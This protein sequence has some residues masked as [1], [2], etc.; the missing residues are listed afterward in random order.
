[1]TKEI[2][3]MTIGVLSGRS[4][5]VG[6]PQRGDHYLIGDGGEP[7]VCE[8]SHG[9]FAPVRAIVFG[10]SCQLC[11]CGLL[12]DECETPAACEARAKEIEEEQGW[13]DELKASGE[14]G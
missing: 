2:E 6:R 7:I 8:G 10:P 13:R 12:T 5:V 11:L 1:M 9:A 3:A 14:L 4:F